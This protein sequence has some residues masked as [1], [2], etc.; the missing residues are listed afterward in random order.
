[1]QSPALKSTSCVILGTSFNLSVPQLSYQQDGGI[2]NIYFIEFSDN[3]NMI[4]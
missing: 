1:M 4:A 2:Y 3:K